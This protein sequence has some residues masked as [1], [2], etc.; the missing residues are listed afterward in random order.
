[1]NIG[2]DSSCRAQADTAWER[3]RLHSLLACPQTADARKSHIERLCE[4]CSGIGVESTNRLDIMLEALKFQPAH[5]FWPVFIDVWSC[6]DDTWSVSADL[7]RALRR[8]HAKSPG[9]RYLG[10][11]DRAFFDVLPDPVEVFRGCR[12]PRVRG[13]SW[14]TCA[15]VAAGFARGHRGIR[16]PD[17]VIAQAMVPKAAVFAAF[18]D[19]QEQE[20]VLDPR[21]FKAAERHH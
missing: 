2:K 20:L 7:R 17:P 3:A 21:R 6:C 10:K 4:L 19:R 16:V 14:T 12:R 15:T 9:T 1:M 11:A 13:V 18:T 5:V 8:H